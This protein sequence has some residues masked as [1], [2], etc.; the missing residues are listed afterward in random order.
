MKRL[1]RTG[2]S[3]PKAGTSLDDSNVAHLN[4]TGN[5]SFSLIYM[6]SRAREIKFDHAKKAPIMKSLLNANLLSLLLLFAACNQSDKAIKNDNSKTDKHSVS[7]NSA[8]RI[9]DV[10]GVN[11]HYLEQGEGTPIVFVHPGY[12]DYRTWRNQVDA[13]SKDYRVI[14]YSRRYSFPNNI[15][16][17]STS[18]FSMVHV[19]DL[20]SVIKSLDAG[21]VHLVGHSAGGWIALQAAIQ[22]PELIK[23]LILGE[24]AVT[25]F[26][27]SDSL[28]ESHLKKFIQGLMRSNEAYRLNEDDKAVEIFF[29]LVM[30]KEDYFQTLSEEDREIIMDNVNESK[31]A[32]LVRNPKGEAPS[33]ITCKKLHELTIPVLLVCGENSPEFVSYMQNKLEPCLQTKERVT[34]SNTSHGLHYESPDAFNKA[35]LQFMRKH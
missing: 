25:D 10:N 14:A 22:H 27:N 4:V 28:G 3:E 15:P 7:E 11:L 20:I 30:G 32:S 33:P 21:P 19:N 13:F 17:D 5:H 8:L 29:G 6:L 1:S 16:V 23:T 31:A 24:P 18:I 26:Y 9:M 34:L 12:A 35:V 2:L